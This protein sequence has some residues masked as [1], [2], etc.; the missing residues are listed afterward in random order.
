MDISKADLE[1]RAATIAHALRAAFPNVPL[2]AQVPLGCGYWRHD[3]QGCPGITMVEMVS[4]S[5]HSSRYCVGQAYRCHTAANRRGR[6]ALFHSFPPAKRWLDVVDDPL[7]CWGGVTSSWMFMSIPARI[8]YLPAYVLTALPLLVAIRFAD[9]PYVSGRVAPIEFVGDT[10][11]ALISP[12][13]S[14]CGKP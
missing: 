12:R 5:R 9:L 1:Q 14:R 11:A 8:Y 10:I 2:P 4:T 7:L 3:E 13:V 6:A